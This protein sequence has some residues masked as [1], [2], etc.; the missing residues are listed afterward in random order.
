[1][2]PV[3]AADYLQS[4]GYQGRIFNTYNWGSYL[5]WRLGP[6]I[7]VAAD[8][9]LLNIPVNEAMRNVSLDPF[10]QKSDKPY[11]KEVMDQ[12]EI[13]MAVVPLMNGLQ[14]SSLPPLFEF[15]HEWRLV[16]KDQIS[17]VYAR[18]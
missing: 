16:F 18:N 10:R 9:R 8:S 12:N 15:D 11:W 14:P 6:D 1:M 17:A 2:F 7:K 13:D 4:S 5:L 3:K